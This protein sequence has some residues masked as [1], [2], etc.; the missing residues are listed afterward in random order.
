MII[1]IL[2]QCILADFKYLITKNKK[3]GEGGIR[4]RGTPFGGSLA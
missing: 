2:A 4:T 1:T 3:D